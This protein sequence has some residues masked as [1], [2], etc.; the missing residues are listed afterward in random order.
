MKTYVRRLASAGTMLFVALIVLSI[1]APDALAQSRRGGRGATSAKSRVER[2]K[3][4]HEVTTVRGTEGRAE[5]A[6]KKR[7]GSDRSRVASRPERRER[8]DESAATARRGHERTREQTHTGRSGTAR[9]Q[10]T[11]ERSTEVVEYGR[12]SVLVKDRRVE[13]RRSVP[14]GS[15]PAYRP[16]RK[17]RPRVVI[18][19]NL[20]VDIHWPWEYRYRRHWR[21]RYRY[22]QVVYV[23][24]GWGRRHRRSRIEVQTY[25]RH[26]VRYA[27]R[28]YAEIDIEIEAVEVYENGRFIGKV[29]HIPYTLG[30]IRATVFRSGYVDFD[31]DVFI[32]G[33]PYVGFEMVSARH[34]EGYVLDAYGRRDGL[35]VGRLDFRGER[36]YSVAYS[37][38]FAP[39]DFDGYVPITLLPEDQEWLYDYGYDAVSAY[40]R[41]YDYYGDAAYGDDYD[42]VTVVG[43]AGI[44]FRSERASGSAVARAPRKRSDDR[45][46]R[47]QNGAEI[48]LKRE[49]EIERVN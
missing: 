4:T 14:H 32:V 38:L 11:R 9:R 27:T 13:S 10:E 33:D 23:E 15:R 5:R 16:K 45:S 6:G 48:R 35:E 12:R 22:R 18:R 37:R 43:G 36:V 30:R 19:P 29:H 41:E 3:L 1:A 39:D 46:F 34:R 7:S 8:R 28:D 49:M 40:D 20:Y 25:Y 31:R 42:G 44:S 2:K 17:H 21:P 47:V 26:T 24:A